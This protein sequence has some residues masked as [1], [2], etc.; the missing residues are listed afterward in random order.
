MDFIVCGLAIRDKDILVLGQ[1]RNSWDVLD[2]PQIAQTQDE[3]SES[4]ETKVQQETLLDQQTQLQ[5][6]TQNNHDN[7]N[8]APNQL[9]QLTNKNQIILNVY[10]RMEKCL[11]STNL[12]FQTSVKPN[13]C[14][15]GNL[16]GI[17]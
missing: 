7:I 3:Q 10:N 15:L 13:E 11:S 2:T 5:D 4:K 6:N 14:K 1:S 12:E 8:K 9:N 16:S 17:N